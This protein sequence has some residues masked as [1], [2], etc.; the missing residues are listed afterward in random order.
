MVSADKKNLPVLNIAWWLK[1]NFWWHSSCLGQCQLIVK[2]LEAS[3]KRCIIISIYRY[4]WT[5]A[6]FKFYF[7]LLGSFVKYYTLFVY[8]FHTATGGL[9]LQ[10]TA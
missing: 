4:M 1:A 7:V 9:C 3:L 5:F 8:F 10:W 2:K 6:F